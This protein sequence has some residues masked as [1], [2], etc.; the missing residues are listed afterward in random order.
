MFTHLVIP[1]KDVGKT[2]W[3]ETEKTKKKKKEYKQ[4][5]KRSKNPQVR[6]NKSENFQI[7][8][9]TKGFKELMVNNK[10]N[11]I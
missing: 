10:V 4:K 9:S 1:F 8:S 6:G 11:Q 5:N 2:I 7:S 3:N